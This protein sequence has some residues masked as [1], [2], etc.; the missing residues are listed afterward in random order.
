V[1]FGPAVLFLSL[2]PSGIEF[3]LFVYGRKNGRWPQLTAGMLLLASPYFASTVTSL[4]ATDAV[5]GAALW[6]LLRV[7]W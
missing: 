6:Y 7:G 1:S 5:I 4:L 3:G 2:I